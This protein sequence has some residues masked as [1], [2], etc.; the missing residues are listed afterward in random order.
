MRRLD[1]HLLFAAALVW[2]VGCDETTDPPTDTGVADT[3]DAQPETSDDREFS[4][5]IGKYGSD[6]SFTTLDETDTVDVVR[7]FQS[8][9][10]VRLALLAPERV[11]RTFSA[12]KKVHFVDSDEHDFRDRDRRVR[13]DGTHDGKRL[14][15][16]FRVPFGQDMSLLEG[17]T[18]E[19]TVELRDEGWHGTGTAHFKIAEETTE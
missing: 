9:K 11:P 6:G 15:R 2:T 4:L 13:F 1:L 5:T 18:V 7:G 12:T 17:E 14:A 16:D 3:R 19:L 8:I 10:F